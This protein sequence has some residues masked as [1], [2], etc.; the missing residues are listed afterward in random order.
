M[1][2]LS[3][4]GTDCQECWL[5]GAW[6]QSLQSKALCVVQLS[7]WSLASQ[8]VPCPR[9]AWNATGTHHSI[10]TEEETEAQETCCSQK[11]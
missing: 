3:S 7:P 5:L 8:V 9:E 6:I 1:K 4:E 11:M 2:S 10:F